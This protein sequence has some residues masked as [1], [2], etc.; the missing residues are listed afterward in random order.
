ME[1]NLKIIDITPNSNL[2][3]SKKE[4]D[5]DEN[6][7]WFS[8]KDVLDYQELNTSSFIQALRQFWSYAVKQQDNYFYIKLTEKEYIDICTGLSRHINIC[9][10][11]KVR[12]G[13]HTNDLY[14]QGIGFIYNYEI[15]P[16]KILITIIKS[17]Y[18]MK[19]RQQETT[20]DIILGLKYLR[21]N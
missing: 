4:F 8:S 2:K 6:R 10:Y 20:N 1:Y 7:L 17:K 21:T 18:I 11:Y 15:E 9:K 16:N 14:Y 13:F 3:L 19:H 5:I 12:F